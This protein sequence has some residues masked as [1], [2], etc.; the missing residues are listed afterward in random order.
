[1]ERLFL[2]WALEKLNY[3][4]NGTVL[5]EIT[6]SNS[7]K[8]LLKMETLN[9]H[10]LIWQMAIQAYRGNMNIAHKYGNINENADALSRWALANTRENPAWVS[11]QEHHIEGICVTDIS[12]ELYN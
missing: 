2:V 8:S 5:D 9:R 1:M 12:T 6:D 10:M 7:V 11:Q 4:L 3:Y